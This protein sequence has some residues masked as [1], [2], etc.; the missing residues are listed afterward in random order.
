MKKSIIVAIVL[1]V[2]FGTLATLY[3]NNLSTKL[4]NETD[5]YL[6]DITLQTAYAIKN[7]INENLTQLETISLM[8]QQ[9]DIKDE[10]LVNYLNQLAKRDGVKRYGIA[11][12]DGNTITSD[13]QS[14][15][16]ADREYFQASLKGKNITSNTINDYTDGELINVYS[17]PIY[18]S[19]EVVTGVLFATFYTEKFSSILSSASYNDAGYSFIFNSRGEVVICS[20]KLDDF[21]NINKFKPIN[22]GELK[23][24]K[25]GIYKFRDENNTLN[26][27]IYAAIEDSNWLVASVFPQETVTKEFQK[28]IQ[29]AFFTWIGLGVGSALLIAYFYF[30]QGKNN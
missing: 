8:I 20:K 3:T 11:D 19:Q 13:Y 25:N 10:T 2:V 9:E 1:L 5:T 16:I 4:Y 15:N 7:R 18:N 26:Y 29:S 22:N 24:Q 27:L 12:I 21:N 6:N 30:K 17:V 28:F 23:L 14:F